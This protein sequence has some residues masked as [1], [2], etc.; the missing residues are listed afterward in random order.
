[1][2]GVKNTILILFILVFIPLAAAC[3]MGTPAARPPATAI[4]QAD[5]TAPAYKVISAQTA[6]D[7][8]QD[9]KD[10]SDFVI[11]DVR[12][13]DEFNSGHIAG[14]IMIDINSP[15]FKAKLSEIDRNKIY[16]VYC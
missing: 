8:I 15:N 1:M 4:P 12:T 2:T 11:L 7:M 5:G 16:L 10:N 3:V 14:A 6:Y 13:P 9:N